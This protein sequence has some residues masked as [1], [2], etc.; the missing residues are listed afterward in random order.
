MAVLPRAHC[1]EKTCP[2]V[3]DRDRRRKSFHSCEKLAL[4]L[5]KGRNQRPPSAV[6]GGMRQ[7]AVRARRSACRRSSPVAIFVEAAF[8][9][10]A[11]L[12][13]VGVASLT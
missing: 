5:P 12:M 4:N 3:P 8:D 10:V 9:G 11:M 6:K 13:P 7:L 1:A 2:D